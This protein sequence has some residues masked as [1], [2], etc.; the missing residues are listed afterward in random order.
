MATTGRYCKAYTVAR[1]RE[2]SRWSEN[3]ENARK[4]KITLD[5]KE[6]DVPRE[7][8][9]TDHLYLHENYTVSDGIFTDQNLI[10][11]EITPEWIEF[12][13]ETLRFY[14]PASQPASAN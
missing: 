7:L 10:F 2:F 4:K 14:P 5:G 8:T 11:S 12:C 9:A 1:Y 3:A 13:R 6:V